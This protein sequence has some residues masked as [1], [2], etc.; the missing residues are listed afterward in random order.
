MCLSVPRMDTCPSIPVF[1]SFSFLSQS[2]TLTC[3]LALNFSMLT[4]SPYS[5]RYLCYQVNGEE[6][7]FVSFSGANDNDH[8][9]SSVGAHSTTS[10]LNRTVTQRALDLYEEEKVQ[11]EDSQLEEKERQEF[12]AI[13]ASPSAHHSKEQ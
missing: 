12:L 13:E 6:L 8:D 10:S 2:V 1:R 11:E 4:V 3:T 5:T 9:A 7:Q